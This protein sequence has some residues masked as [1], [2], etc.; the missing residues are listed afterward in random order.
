MTMK[1][2][3][4]VSFRN[5]VVELMSRLKSK[6]LGNCRDHV[7]LLS[8]RKAPRLKN[9]NSAAPATVKSLPAFLSSK[10]G[11]GKLVA[12]SE[13]LEIRQAEV[14]ILVGDD[15]R[16]NTSRSSRANPIIKGR[17]LNAKIPNVEEVGFDATDHFRPVRFVRRWF[18][19]LRGQG[20][21]NFWPCRRRG[22]RP[23][24]NHDLSEFPFEALRR[25]S[26][27]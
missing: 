19:Q 16:L 13:P 25:L 7:F 23:L 9:A 10:I 15:Y 24:Q 8:N 1:A 4:F 5:G 14:M 6:F 21:R 17:E 26:N 3:A 27:S 12:A 22:L 2:P 20:H 18:F 11:K